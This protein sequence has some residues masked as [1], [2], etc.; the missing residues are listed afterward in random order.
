MRRALPALVLHAV[1]VA[2]AVLTLVP[3]AWM[4]AASLMPAG[5][6]NTFPPRWI[7]SRPTLEHFATLFTRLDLARA[8]W[9]SAVVT[10]LATIGS[11]IVTGAAGYAFAKLRFR[12]RDGLFA[13][14]SSALVVPAQVAMLPLFLVLRE[15]GLVNSVPGVVIPYLA[16]VYGIFLI[17]Q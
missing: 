6:A 17:R 8:F 13:G 12:G 3:L 11:V 14:L 16:S 9:N 7:P 10:T 1:L 15:M 2:G 4:I 5:E